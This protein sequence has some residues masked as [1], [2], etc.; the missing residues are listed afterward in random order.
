MQRQR[1]D[2]WFSALLL[3]A[4]LWSG[5]AEP[6]ALRPT[7]LRSDDPRVTGQGDVRTVDILFVVD[8]SNSMCEEQKRLLESFDAFVQS[9]ATAKADFHLAVVNTDMIDLVG[10]Q[11]IFRT[12]PGTYLENV[13]SCSETIPD[14]SFC[15]GKALPKF[16]SSMSYGGLETPEQLASLQSDFSCMVLTGIDGSPVEMGL[17]AARQAL[18]RADQQDFFRWG[19]LLAI[20]F[21]SD[22]NDCSDTTGTRGALIGPV[23]PLEDNGCEWNRNLEDSCLLPDPNA[24]FGGLSALEVCVEG[25]RNTLAGL[26]SELGVKCEPDPSTGAPCSNKLVA[27]RTFYDFLVKKVAE[28]NRYGTDEAGL[29]AAA[30]DLIVAAIINTDAGVRYNSN[31]VLDGNWCNGSLSFPTAGTQGYRYQLFAEMFPEAHRVISPICDD[32]NGEAVNFGPPL[33]LIGNVIGKAINTVCMQFRPMQCDPDGMDG[34]ACKPGARCCPAGQTCNPERLLLGVEGFEYSVC[35]G[36]E[37][38]VEWHT[39]VPNTVCETNNECV[40]P[41]KCSVGVCNTVDVLVRDADYTL[42]LESRSCASTTGSPIEL[43]LRA[44]PPS[45]SSLVVSY[46]REVM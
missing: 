8:N 32:T 14:T 45:G 9:L 17:E 4:A 46:P 13:A 37:V 10:G 41:Q 40:A 42:D 15:A 35:S 18:S 20:V 34:E 5:C 6:I 44:P 12:S 11:G 30:N 3:A 39:P 25:N 36:F 22:E 29:K 19:S 27:R 21:V 43:G 26:A 16:L 38:I 2:Y 1:F 33:Q 24:T 28:R 23:Y 7:E 31:E